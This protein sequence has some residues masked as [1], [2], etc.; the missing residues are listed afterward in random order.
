MCSVERVKPGL[1]KVNGVSGDEA[2]YIQRYKG[3]WILH[4][5]S[6]PKEDF[7]YLH[8]AQLEALKRAERY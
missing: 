8:D 3:G 2:G 6:M 5:A 1:Y 4:M 7:H